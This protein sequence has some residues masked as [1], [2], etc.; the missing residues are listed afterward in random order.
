MLKGITEFALARRPMILAVLLVFFGAGLYAYTHLNIEAY[1]DPTPPIVEIIT[2]NPGQSAE[3]IERYITIPVEIALA[4]MPGL[5]FV[6]S[7]SLYGLSFIRT[8]FSYDTTYQFALQQVINRLTTVPNL[9]NNAQPTISPTSP[10]GEILRYQLV[11][12]PGVSV[13]DLKTLQDWVL[14][15]RFKTIP[16]VI[17]VVGWGGLTKEYHVEVDLNK[18]MAYNVTLPQ[19]MAAISNSNVNVGARTLSIGAQAANVRGIGLI[20]SL[21]DMNNIVLTQAGGTPVFL[22]DV[23]KAEIGNTPRLGIAGRDGDSD[24]VQGIVLMRRGEKTR[25]V[26]ERVK[27]EMARMQSEGLLPPGVQLVPFY[28]RGNLVAVTTGTVLHNLIMGILLVFVIQWVFLGDLRSA[29]IVSAT[30]PCAL[31]FSTLLLVLRGESANLLSI[32]A[33]DFGIIVDSTVILVENVF[34]HLREGGQALP[35]AHPASGAGAPTTLTGK[36]RTILLSALEVDKAIFF[37]AAILLAAFLPLF[38]MQGVEGQIFAPMAKTYGYALLGALLT[39]FTI[40]PVLSAFLLPETFLERETVVVRVLRSGYVVLL[41]GA[42]RHRLLTMLVALGVLVGTALVLPRLG[43]EFLPKLEEGNLW[44]R[45]SLP[46]SIS[47]EAGEPAAARI[48]DILRSY[49]EVITVI[50]QH[51]RPDDGTDPAGFYNLEIFAPLKPFEDWPKGWTK[52]RLV[53]TLQEQLAQEFPGVNF[54]FSQY[55]QDNV[56]EAVSGVKGENS[57]KLFGRD[58]TVLEAKAQEIKAQLATVRGVQDLG[59]FT[60]LGQPNLLIRIDRTRDARYGLAPGDVNAVVQAAVGGQPV[61]TIFE[62]ERQIPLVVRL[63]P[64]YR[65]NIE[66]IKEIHVA[67]QLDTQ[68]TTAYVPLRELAQITMETGASYIYRENYARYIPIKFSVRDRDLGSTISEAQAKIAQHVALPSGYRIV[69]SGEFGSLQE[70]KKRL[71]VI[72]PLSLVLIIVLLYSMFNSV[73]DSLLAL[74]GIPFAVCGGILGLYLTGE[75]LSVS[76]AVGFISLFGVAVM[77]GILL[78]TYYNQLREAAYP[79]VA[80]MRRAAEVRMRPMLMTALSACIGLLPAAMSHGIGSQVQRPLATV[81]VGGMFLA[82]V[83]ILVV[84]PV[85]CLVVLGAR[86]EA[87]PPALVEVER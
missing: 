29:L 85:L 17:D 19:V 20:A 79:R 41:R 49:P 76:A 47:L 52:E 5:Q 11:G 48:R 56:E 13:M 82:P 37:S 80:A 55:I 12:P 18:L 23:A 68:G 28:D 7:I 64:Q 39:T 27:A 25:E 26:L 31:F 65:Q 83:L 75:N 62:G 81:V 87:A 38:T 77:A 78:L 84:V 36:A 60:V 58:L 30:I 10:V 32:G 40:S 8:Q 33:I 6:R 51:G 16:G 61:T 22:R 66:A 73:R 54:N 42:I 72:V 14:E 71:A 69:W 74:A 46:P 43:T 24:I 63:L 4:G 15:R 3:E 59:I 70:A 45:A 50:T 9:P 67:S 86:E 53:A 21:E 44:I 57:V 34:R 1:P 35:Q 2:Q